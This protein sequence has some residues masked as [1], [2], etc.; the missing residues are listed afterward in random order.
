MLTLLSDLHFRP[1]ED[2]RRR[3]QQQQHQAEDVGRAQQQQNNNSNGDII[4]LN[5]N[6]KRQQRQQQQ[7]ADNMNKV[8]QLPLV[9]PCKQFTMRGTIKGL[10]YCSLL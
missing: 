7:Q 4:I 5:N 8:Q 2:L 10:P 9:S 3:A 1:L 6:K